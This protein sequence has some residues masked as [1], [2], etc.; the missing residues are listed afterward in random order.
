[1][2]NF[3]EINRALW[4]KKK[5]FTLFFMAVFAISS[6][7]AHVPVSNSSGYS[8]GNA[9]WGGFN[10]DDKSETL[11]F[12]GIP[13]TLSFSYK[14]SSKSATQKDELS[15]FYIEESADNSHWTTI[16]ENAQPTTTSTAVS[17]IPLQKSTRYLKFHYRGNFAGYFTNIQVSELVYVEDPQPASLDLGTAAINAGEVSGSV[18]VN[19]CSVSPLSVSCDDSRFTV[20]PASFGAVDQY[21]SQQI[22]VKYTHTSEVGEHNG[23]I[24]ISNGTYT[25]TVAVHANTI[26]RVQT[27]TWNPELEAT[28]FAMNVG[29]VYPD[30]NIEAIATAA[31]GGELTYSSSDAE[32]VSVSVDGKVLTAVGVG[33]AEI[34]AY[35][36]GDAEYQEVS[37]TKTFV[38]TNLT[39]QSITWEQSLLSLLTTSEPVELTATAS[40]GGDIAYESADESVVRIEG[41]SLIVVGEGETY[42]TAT[43]AGGD[44]SGE[45]YL[46]ISQT[47]LVVV[48]NPASQCSERALSQ[49]TLKLN[50]NKL[51]QEYT[52]AGAP[53]TLTFSALHGTKSGS[54]IGFSPIYNSLIVEQFACINNLWDWYKVYEQVVGT[55]ATASGN[56]SLDETA[57]KIRFRTTETGTDHT[58]SNINVTRKKFMRADV[59]EINEDAEANAIWEKTITINHSNIDMMTVT[60]QNGLLTVS[61]TLL[62][63]G[64]GDYGN[65]AFVVTFTP[66]VRGADYEDVI[67]ITDSKAQPT[68][69]E[70]PVTLHAVGFN[71]SISGFE[72]P[73]SCTTTDE[74]VLPT[75]TASSNLEVVYL[76]SDSTI[77]YVENGQLVIL[78]AGTVDIIAYQAG[79]ERYNEASLAKTIEI[80]L[81]PV[82]I[83]SVQYDLEIATGAPLS[84]SKIAGGL[85]SADGGVTY[86]EGTFAWQNP[87]ETPA[88]G[89]Q[90]C[91]VVFT[92]T[93]SNIYATAT[94]QVTVEV[95]A[96]PTT[97]GEYTAH[98]CDGEEIDFHGEV[99]DYATDEPI[100]VYLYDENQYGGDSI[101]LLTVIVHMPEY[102]ESFDT[103]YVGDVLSVEPGVWTVNDQVLNEAEYEM[104]EATSFDL[105]QTGQTEFG[106]DKVITRHITVEA[107]VETG[108]ENVQGDAVQCTKELR[109]GILYIRRDGKEYTIT[110]L[111]VK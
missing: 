77:A 48:R 76:S 34:T 42:V 29:D 79:D 21:G 11:S 47:K 33:T 50:A 71:Q 22:D 28:G 24:T 20:T 25:K 27:V 75:A 44:I 106:C 102:V 56:I 88:E 6:F 49:S 46:A 18:L 86:L 108:V 31:S 70:I 61:T 59:A 39:R 13:G 91:T 74:V 107:K 104:T 54:F 40:S 67:V 12:T 63:E 90:S 16:W 83:V 38:V 97:Y 30:V 96:N 89:F 23:T 103:L 84:M 105:V 17:N 41:N 5:I 87:D 57:T 95:K 1:M 55:S 68:T 111:Q 72:L 4:A 109:N 99:V 60:T 92:P 58:I 101:V 73:K 35:N 43:Q 15:H 32:V 100:E 85:A 64:C 110:G 19:W 81:T 78:A 93:L 26:K 94:T 82:E 53:E 45:E 51:S 14:Y 10:W 9:T 62:G 2:K 69:I 37:D 66:T 52:L 8:M 7:A 65:D 80:Q 98:I 36:A 3:Y